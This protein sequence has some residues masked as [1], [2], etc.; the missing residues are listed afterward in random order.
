M[1]NFILFIAI[2][3]AQ[4][5]KDDGDCKSGRYNFAQ[6][7]VSILHPE[8]T[9]PELYDFNIDYGSLNAEFLEN[10]GI[11]LYVT[12]QGD[13]QVGEGIRLSTTRFI[14]YG[15]ITARIAAVGVPGIVTAF[16]TMSPRKDEIDFETVGIDKQAIQTNVFYKGIE[17]RGVHGGRHPLSSPITEFHNYSIDWRPDEIIFSID[18][19]VVRI[20]RKDGPE[21]V[22]Q[23]TD[24]QWFPTEASQVQFSVWDAGNNSWAGGP[25]SWDALS[26]NATI[27]YVDIKCFEEETE[28]IGVDTKSPT[29]SVEM[30]SVTTTPNTAEISSIGSEEAETISNTVL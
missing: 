5:F 23:M 20:H 27:E 12:K 2:A 25:V 4:I 10:G 9:D 30:S 1:V 14:K 18:E 24:E 17:E 7:R 16:I 21:S 13:G 6:D 8:P 29:I 15:K 3:N 19:E 11:N 28:E 26:Y 22:S